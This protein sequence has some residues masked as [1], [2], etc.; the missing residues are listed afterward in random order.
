MVNFMNCF[1]EVI[2]LGFLGNGI[3]L[4]IY[5]NCIQLFKDV[6]VLIVKNVYKYYEEG[7]DSVLLCSIVICDVFLNVMILDIVM[8][9]FINIVFYFLVIVYEVEVDFKMDDIDMFLC[10]VFCLCKVVLNIQKYYIQDVNCVG[11]IFNILGE[12]FKGG[13]LKIDVK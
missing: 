3:I 5:V 2:G 11:G 4:V 13:L 8:G 10:Y 7:D 9:G 1:N 12:L 6:V